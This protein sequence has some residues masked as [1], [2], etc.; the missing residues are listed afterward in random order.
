MMTMMV[1]V[2]LFPSRGSPGRAHTE[3]AV[4]SLAT[5]IAADLTAHNS[6]GKEARGL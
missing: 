1:L 4:S 6:Q 3:P 2:V 5:A